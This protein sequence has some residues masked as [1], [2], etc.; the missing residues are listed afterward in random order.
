MSDPLVAAFGARLRNRS[1]FLVLKVLVLC[2]ELQ[3]SSYTLY[4]A[5]LPNTCRRCP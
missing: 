1:V 4:I 5:V 2:T 3:Y